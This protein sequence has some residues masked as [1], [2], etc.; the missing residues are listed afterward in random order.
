[1]TMRMLSTL[2]GVVAMLSP[3]LIAS[4]AGAAQP[5]TSYHAG[6]VMNG[7]SPM[8]WCD[9]VE[10]TTV[11]RS[12]VQIR[13]DANGTFIQNARTTVVFTAT[14]SGRSV[15]YSDAG[16]V[17]LGVV[18]NADGTTTYLS[19]G[20]GVERLFKIANGPVLTSE[21]GQPLRSAG[22]SD[23]AVTFD[24]ATGELISF[25]QS[26]HGPHPYDDGVD[27]CGPTVAYLQAP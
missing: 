22:E 5:V 10:G 4:S 7:P 16:V 27:V 26:V 18:D 23:S 24:T 3:A 1:M 21:S 12:V 13:E 14:A 2:T 11:S 8:S 20:A 15:E 6:P 17:K 19:K 25:T 9:Q